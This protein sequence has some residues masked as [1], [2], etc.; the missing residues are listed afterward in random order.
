MV[1]PD[2]KSTVT[3]LKSLLKD[4][5]GLYLATDVTRRARRSP[6]ICSKRSNRG[7]RSADGVPRSPNRRSAPPPTNRATSTT[8]S[9]TPETRRIL[10]RLYGYEV[11]PVLWKKVMPEAV[12]GPRAV[13][14]H[15]HH[16]RPERERMAFTSADH[17]WDIAATLDAGRHRRPSPPGHRRR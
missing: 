1:S 7:S 5:D 8:T 12:G 13:G 16:R 15:P 2:K 9:S 11:S 10:D 4:V 3:E 6:G 17:Y 14:G